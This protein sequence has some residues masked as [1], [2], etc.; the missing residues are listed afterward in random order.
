M[1]CWPEWLVKLPLES[2]VIRMFP[3]P[4]KLSAI[5]G[6]V[7]ALIETTTVFGA[8]AHPDVND[9]KR[10]ETANYVLAPT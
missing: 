5:I 10:Q 2:E 1:R 4:A 7:A 6:S 9:Q 8:L 3:E